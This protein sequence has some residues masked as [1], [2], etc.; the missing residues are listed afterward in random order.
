[1]TNATQLRTVRFLLDSGQI[2]LVDLK[3][4]G[5]GGRLDRNTALFLVVSSIRETHVTGLVGSDNA[6]LRDQRVGKR[7]L[8]VVD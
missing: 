7:R 8:A 3:E 1:M 4:H 2:L 5:D 6:G